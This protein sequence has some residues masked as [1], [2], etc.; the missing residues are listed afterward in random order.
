LSLKPPKYNGG[1]VPETVAIRGGSICSDRNSPSMSTGVRVQQCPKDLHPLQRA[2]IPR[3]GLERL[4]GD[5]GGDDV[6]REATAE[7]LVERGE[8][9]GELGHPELAHPDRREQ[10]HPTDLGGDG[11]GEGDRVDPEGVAGRQQ[12][13]VVAQLVGGEHDVAAVRIA[14]LQRRVG[15]A[16]ELVVVVAQRAE[17]GDLGRGSGRRGLV[18]HRRPY[19]SGSPVDASTMS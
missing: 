12:D 6:D 1:Q 16:Q 11:R 8:L 2:P 17:P 14:G 4:T 9:A 18:H 19:G 13:V 5:V 15:L 7:D 10:P 3:A